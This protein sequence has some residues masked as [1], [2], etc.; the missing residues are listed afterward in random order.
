MT[1]AARGGCGAQPVVIG[2]SMSFSD[3]PMIRKTGRRD[4]FI[5]FEVS[6]SVILLRLSWMLPDAAPAHLLLVF[7]T[8]T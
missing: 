2:S 7:A 6:P 4:C 3:Q 8:P 5:L 1:C